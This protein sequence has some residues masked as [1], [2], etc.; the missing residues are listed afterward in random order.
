MSASIASITAAVT[1]AWTLAKQ[2]RRTWWHT[3]IEMMRGNLQRKKYPG[4]E[5]ETPDEK[6]PKTGDDNLPCGDA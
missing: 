5:K 2:I 1:G 3:C 6:R 4:F